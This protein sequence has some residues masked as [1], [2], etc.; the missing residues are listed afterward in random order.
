MTLPCGFQEMAILDRLFGRKVLLTKEGFCG[1]LGLK[2][3][4]SV[5]GM[6]T[7]RLNNF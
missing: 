1:F 5:I 6:L 3:Y 7:H 2:L 4:T